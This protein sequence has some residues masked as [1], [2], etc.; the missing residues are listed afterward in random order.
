M[1]FFPF[2]AAKLSLSTLLTIGAFFGV[3]IVALGYSHW[4]GAVKTAF[5]ILLF[6]GAIRKWAFPQLQE[7]V[8]FMKDVILLGPYLKFFLSPDPEIRAWRLDIPSFMLGILVL[9]LVPYALNPNIGS[10]MLGMYGLKIYIYYVPLVFMMP[11]LFRTREEMVRQLSLYVLIG[12]PIC[13][14]GLAQWRA[15]PGS[16][17]NVYAQL[18]AMQETGAIGFGFGEKV[19]IT[20]TFSYI[21]G[22]TTFVIF[23]TT[24][25]LMLLS[26][27]ETKWKWVLI[28]VCAPL[29]LAN[30]LM[31]GSRAFLYV[32]ALVLVGFLLAGISGK[33]GV[34]KNFLSIMFAGIVVCAA[35]AAYFFY[36]AY[37]YMSKRTSSSADSLA[38]RVIEHPLS[39]M[40]M[41]LKEAGAAGYGIGTTHP[42][43]EAIRRVMRIPAPKMRPPVF[44]MEPGQVL[45]EVGPVGFL[46]WYG[47]RIWLLLLVWDGFQKAPA[48]PAKTV[49]LAAMLVAIPHFLLG[50]IFNHTSNMLLFGMI[51]LAMLT[52]LQPVVQRRANRPQNPS[53]PRY[54]L[55]GGRPAPAPG[56]P[57]I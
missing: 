9:L 1:H 53:P 56:L 8:Y 12:I 51:G 26:L 27:Q 7:L 4:R 45:V 50:V 20:G 22:H 37:S 11:Y 34:T 30:G 57:R 24:L 54:S 55:R 39:A 18:E 14:L 16:P 40:E 48:S 23:F 36:D 49:A 25:L 32:D 3:I 6:E 19:R 46:A 17:L 15:G 35:G 42:A 5:V 28:C 33:I 47:L 2:L 43:T 13:L 52:R 41:G 29:L 10:V 31:S 44:D 21:T 38:F